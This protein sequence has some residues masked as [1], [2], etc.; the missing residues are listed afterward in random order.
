MSEKKQLFWFGPEAYNWKHG[1]KMLFPDDPVTEEVI[2][3]VGQEASDDLYTKGYIVD[4]TPGLARQQATV[5]SQN[6]LKAARLKIAALTKERDELAELLKKKVEPDA[7]YNKLTEE[8]KKAVEDINQLK[9]ENIRLVEETDRCH[10]KLAELENSLTKAQTELK[11]T[12]AHN[13]TLHRKIAQLEKTL[14]KKADTVQDSELPALDNQKAGPP[15]SK[16][17]TDV[18]TDN[19]SGG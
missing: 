3:K 10:E 7:E 13:K 6:N 11:K 19:S 5:T 17:K 4:L 16:G 14:G 12:K 2:A 18:E 15:Q 9:E 1:E 8:Y